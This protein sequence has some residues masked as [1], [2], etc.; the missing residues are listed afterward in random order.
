MR[1]IKKFIERFISRIRLS[2]NSHWQRIWIGIYWSMTTGRVVVPSAIEQLNFSS[3]GL[4][5]NKDFK[6]LRA[7]QHRWESADNLE[8]EGHWHQAMRI[9]EEVMMELYAYQGIMDDKY[10]PPILASNWSSNFGH[11][12]LIG[13]HRLAQK[14]KILPTGDRTIIYNNKNPNYELLREVSNEMQLITQ[15]S[16]TGWSDMT[17]FW[18]FCERMQAVKTVYG[19]VDGGQMV[20]EIFSE[21]NLKLLQGDFLRLS[22]EYSINSLRKLQEY[23][24]P[25]SI[26]FVA[27]HIRDGG[28]IGDPR[29]QKI[30]TFVSS[31]IEITKSG[32]WV[33]RV[34]DPGM[35]KLP[36]MKMV[37][38]LVP[39]KNSAKELHA[40]VLA[41]CEFFLGTHSGPAWV[42]RVF[43][44]PT[45]ITNA[46][47][48]GSTV[49]RGPRGSIHIPKKYIDQKGK[50]LTLSELFDS[51]LAF[52]SPS[53]Y[54]L[55]SQ[56]FELIDNTSDEILEST[57]EMIRNISKDSKTPSIFAESVDSIR[58]KYN[59]PL[60]GKFSDSFIEKYPQ[61]IR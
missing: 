36:N 46:V 19:F 58:R 3:S 40:F 47:K 45:L 18:H 48:I 13:H 2:I 49:A 31:I 43:G 5:P 42:P 32:F 28:K 17:N 51:R 30:E 12:A 14:L 8:S 16:G 52:S 27:L 23:G 11:L 25:K 44:I 35:P 9:R 1:L 57:K 29:T 4:I 24:L 7:H 22:E 26:K 20:D 55:K 56:G 39:K 50:I 6:I 54:K 38:D 34:G 15:N 37:V 61:W 60:W 53:L 33:V 10:F 59:A 21:V 41:N